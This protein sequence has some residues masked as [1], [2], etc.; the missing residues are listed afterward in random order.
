ML[1]GAEQNVVPVPLRAEMLQYSHTSTVSGHPGAIF[2]YDTIRWSN[3]WPHM[4][5]DVYNIVERF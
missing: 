1:E 2:M 4:Q 3:F 5:N